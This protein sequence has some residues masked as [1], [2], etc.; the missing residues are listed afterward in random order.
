MFSGV[1][2]DWVVV[3]RRAARLTQQQQ[4]TVNDIF[5]YANARTPA[6]FC[7]A[8]F[9]EKTR[10][11][12]VWSYWNRCDWLACEY[13][14]CTRNHNP[15][16]TLL[17]EAIWWSLYAPQ[18]SIHLQW[19]QQERPAMCV[20]A[21]QTIP[22]ISTSR[23]DV[24]SEKC[25]YYVVSSLLWWSH[26]RNANPISRMRP[27]GCCARAFVC[28]S[29]WSV[30]RKKPA[31][32]ANTIHSTPATKCIVYTHASV[33]FDPR[34]CSTSA[35]RIRDTSPSSAAQIC[36]HQTQKLVCTGSSLSLS[37]WTLNWQMHACPP[38]THVI[39][40]NRRGME[41]A[42]SAER[43]R[44]TKCCAKTSGHTSRVEAHA[45]TNTSFPT[46]HAIRLEDYAADYA[47]VSSFLFCFYGLPQFRILTF[48]I[49]G[50]RE[51]MN[52]G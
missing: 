14:I 48:V 24:H 12:P 31:I 47:A 30:S 7:L 16:L 19:A 27:A 15:M 51:L 40:K 46:K 29:L 4:K 42:E 32:P 45:D 23:D 36:T 21:G 50:F 34:A 43:W 25:V 10:F 18:I 37:I 44:R 38:N 39:K 52:R 11:C 35:A 49:F 20:S 9:K 3:A 17:S 33:I 28:P 26:T 8:L 2:F 1:W 22:N 13:H 5:N 6:D 41:S